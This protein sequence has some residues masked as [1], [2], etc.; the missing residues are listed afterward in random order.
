MLSNLITTWIAGGIIP[1]FQITEALRNQEACW[2]CTASKCGEFGFTF[3]A[4]GIGCVHIWCAMFL[5]SKWLDIQ[6]FLK[7]TKIHLYV[8]SSFSRWNQS[9]IFL[10]SYSINL[11]FYNT[12]LQLFGLSA[13]ENMDFLKVRIL[14]SKY[15]KLYQQ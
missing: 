7:I 3:R 8:P 10:C 13:Q 9:L 5:P 1:G 4:N 14:V 2:L 6:K 15:L 12:A 11:F